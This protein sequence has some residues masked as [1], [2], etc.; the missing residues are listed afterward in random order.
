MRCVVGSVRR[1]S[2]F[3]ARNDSAQ[4]APGQQVGCHEKNSCQPVVA[5]IQL[6]PAGN[7]VPGAS[8]GTSPAAGFGFSPAVGKRWRRSL[9]ALPPSDARRR[10]N[11]A[12]RL[13]PPAIS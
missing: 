5:Y 6:S 12:G 13:R 7:L 8:T 3:L 11:P 9:W 10:P 2:W 1:A 4:G